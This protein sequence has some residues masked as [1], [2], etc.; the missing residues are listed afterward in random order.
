MIIWHKRICTRGTDQTQ[1]MKA[2]IILTID[3]RKA[4]WLSLMGVEDPDMKFEKFL[5]AGAARVVVPVKPEY[6]KRVLYYT[7]TGT[8][9]TGDNVPAL[10]KLEN[11]RIVDEVEEAN[12]TFFE[13]EIGEPWDLVVPTN[14]VYLNPD[15]TPDLPNYE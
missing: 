1:Y 13:E 11:V 9:W 4:Q 3:S 6:T 5:K 2:N 15:V 12:A 8:I 10:S 14:L 7:E